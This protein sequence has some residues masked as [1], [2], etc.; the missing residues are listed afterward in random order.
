MGKRKTQ[1]EFI[2]EL[3]VINPAIT[4]EGNYANNHTKVLCHCNKCGYTW[5]AT[6]HNLLM[7]HGCIVCAKRKKRTTKEFI[8][9]LNDVNQNIIIIGKYDGVDKKIE[10]QCRICGAKW[11]ARPHNLL[12]GSK[13]PE[14]AIMRNA[15][16]TRKKQSQFIEELSAVSPDI[17]VIGEYANVDTPIE[18]KCN[19]CGHEWKAIPNNLLKGSGCPKCNYYL[20]T[21]F[22][23]QAIYY[24]VKQIY[25]DAIN[26]Y[27]DIFDNNMELD[28]YIPSIN[29]GIEYDGKAWHSGEASFERE[30]RKYAICKKNGICLIRIRENISE[31][32]DNISDI[33]IYRQGTL[34][35]IF[36][37]L[38]EFVKLPSDINIMRDAKAIKTQYYGVLNV[39][40]TTE[41]FVDRMLSVD[42]DIEVLGD[43]I[44]SITPIEVRCKKCNRVWFSTPSS[45]LAGH[46]CTKCKKAAAIEKRSKST[47]DFIVE[48]ANINPDIDVLGEYVNRKVKIKV[49]CKKCGRI[50]SASP[51]SLLTGSGCIYCSGYSNIKK[52]SDEFKRELEEINSEIIVISDYV[53]ANKDITVRCKKCGYEWKTT[54]SKL[55]RGQKCPRENGMIPK[56]TDTFKEELKV[57]NPDIEVLGEYISSKTAIK[58]KCD[59]CGYQWETAPSTL[60][61]GHGCPRCYGNIKKTTEE[62]VKELKIVNSNII[63]LSEYI[64]ATTPITVKC[65]LCGHEWQARPS[66]LLNGHGCP[67][68]GKSLRKSTAQ[69][70]RELQNVNQ[71][72][73]VLGEY[74]NNKTKI[75]VRCK[76]CD[77]EWLVIPNSLLSGH[78]CPRCAKKKK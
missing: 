78:G 47:A 16:R 24:Y 34:E 7:G 21:S 11:E 70:I 17:L 76:I 60:L 13:C 18:V 74:I 50:W 35:T 42:A 39:V 53:S 62:F 41:R 46:G 32:K 30:K 45:L 3:K 2:D 66:H 56:T 69:F 29:V 40:Q 9:D 61:A 57:I 73:E 4:V 23:E 36:D 65:A 5:H 59:K 31:E 72:I 26:G 6:P 77:Y 37:K 63:V 44:N 75:A 38:S 22:P 19:L 51:S 67:I 52:S 55:L 25:P 20:K 1:E 71:N 15:N 48:L 54:P 33:T 10:V 68:E 49:S 43:Y 12:N 58:V 27:K 64:N 28:I 14:C 8:K